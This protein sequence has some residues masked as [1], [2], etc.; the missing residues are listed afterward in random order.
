VDTTGRGDQRVIGRV[1]P[2]GSGQLVLQTLGGLSSIDPARGDVLWT[3]SDVVPESESFGDDRQI[4][5]VERGGMSTR[6]LRTEDGV[7]AHDVPDFANLFRTASRRLLGR[8]VLVVEPGGNAAALRLVDVPTGRELW[9]KEI[10]Q[11]DVNLL[12]SE[13]PYLLGTLDRRGGEVSIVDLRARKEVLKARI[14]P[15]HLPAGTQHYLVADPTTFYVILNGPEDPKQQLQ[16]DPFPAVSGMASVPVNGFVYAFDRAGGKLRWFN[17]VQSQVLVVEQFEELPI[18]LFAA[19]LNR[20]KDNQVT[21]S[22]S[23][24]SIDKRTGKR[25]Y[26]YP[27]DKEPNKADADAANAGG[28]PPQAPNPN[29]GVQLF[30]ALHANPREKTIDLVGPN[31]R[32][33]HWQAA[34]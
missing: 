18:L 2:L 25:L 17:R 21:Q 14:D 5:L 20:Q 34:R 6:A 28:Q 31:L 1:G 13:D 29:N 12:N 3:R 15:V 8:T 19:G 9:K 11:E 4:Y 27:P 23:V 10:A 22:L 32:I 26:A 24:L 30:Y 7:V 33:R 16:G